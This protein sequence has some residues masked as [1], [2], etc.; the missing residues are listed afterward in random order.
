MEDDEITKELD[1]GV[2]DDDSKELDDGVEDD[3]WAK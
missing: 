3:D 2:E 1:D